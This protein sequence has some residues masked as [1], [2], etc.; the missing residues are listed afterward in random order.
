MGNSRKK[1][2]W[3]L[4]FV[5]YFSPS[6]IHPFSLLTVVFFRYFLFFNVTSSESKEEDDATNINNNAHIK[7][8]KI[9]EN[10]MNKVDIA[11]KKWINTISSTFSKKE[12]VMYTSDF[13]Q[14]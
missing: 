11:K 9:D 5:V 8:W 14:T 2:E 3:K 7:E 12:M 1:K 6:I 10:S 4:L 13:Q